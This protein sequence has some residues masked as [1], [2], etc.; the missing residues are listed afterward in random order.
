MTEQGLCG[1]VASQLERISVLGLGLAVA[2]LGLMTALV[3]L[4]VVARNFFDLG[5][6]WADELARLS[7][8]ALTFLALPYLLARGKHIAVEFLVGLLGGRRRRLVLAVAD[9]AV[10]LFCALMLWGFVKFLGRAA[11][12]STPS[13]GLP[14]LVF[15]APAFAGTLLLGLAALLRGLGRLAGA[16]PRALEPPEPESRAPEAREP[17][18]P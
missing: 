5:L 11:A 4:Q 7:G 8:I 10:A 13:L 2:C 12:F 1:R 15:Y 16:A 6:P 3:V 14:N 9:L 18:A 17:G